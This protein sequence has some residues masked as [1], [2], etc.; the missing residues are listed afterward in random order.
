MGTTKAGRWFTE[1]WRQG[2]EGLWGLGKRAE[3][4]VRDQGW[5]LPCPL[6]AR[7]VLALPGFEGRN[8]GMC[9]KCSADDAVLLFE[10]EVVKEEAGTTRQRLRGLCC[11]GD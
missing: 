9:G 7:T 10:D 3:G 4:W 5:S 1:A 6:E 11:S 8:Q 2:W